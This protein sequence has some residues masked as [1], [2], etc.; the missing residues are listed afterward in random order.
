MVFRATVSCLVFLALAMSVSS[1]ASVSDEGTESLRDQVTNAMGTLQFK[2]RFLDDLSSTDYAV[3]RVAVPRSK[4]SIDIAWGGQGVP[5]D[6]PV[7]PVL[8]RFTREGRIPFSEVVSELNI[9]LKHNGYRPNSSKA[10]GV[11]RART[12]N[13]A[14]LALC[15]E[16]YGLYECVD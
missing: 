10:A 8:P 7:P 6:C 16:V 11:A 15:E 9:C 4:D 14:A 3:F 1:C 12:L 13:S 2:Y 5:E